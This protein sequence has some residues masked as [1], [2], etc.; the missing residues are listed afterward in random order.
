MICDIKKIACDDNF[1]KQ[2]RVSLYFKRKKFL[3]AIR[4][5]GRS[6]HWKT[7]K[8]SS[9]RMWALVL[10]QQQNDVLSLQSTDRHNRRNRGTTKRI[11]HNRLTFSEQALNIIHSLKASDK[12]HPTFSKCCQDNLMGYLGYPNF[13]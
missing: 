1:M 13:L 7:W 3:T 6:N 12:R 8:L 10:L 2:I 4:E 9:K 5:E 11:R